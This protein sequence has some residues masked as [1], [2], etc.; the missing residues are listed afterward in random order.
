MTGL[1]RLEADASFEQPEKVFGSALK[2]IFPNHGRKSRESVVAEVGE[3]KESPQIDLWVHL[4]IYNILK[5]DPME[6][7]FTIKTRLFVVWKLPTVPHELTTQQWY[8]QGDEDTELTADQLTYLRSCVILPKMKFWQATIV[9]EQLDEYYVVDPDQ[10]VLCWSPHGTYS[11]PE[12]MELEWF[13]IDMQYLTLRLGIFSTDHE[14]MFHVH[15]HAVEFLPL[16]MDMPEWN[17]NHPK[18]AK[19]GGKVT[20]IHLRVTRKSKYYVVNIVLLMFVLSLVSLTT[21][22]IDAQQVG[23]CL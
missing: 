5:V 12:P 22:G 15:V 6:S 17:M 3:S 7:F 9:E 4:R 20:E 10:G 2:Y 23:R 18:L 11:C 21:F 19:E 14:K 13:P 8:Q 1:V 16:T